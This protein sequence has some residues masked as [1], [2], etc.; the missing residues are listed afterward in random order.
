MLDALD[1]V[2][3]YQYL[4][5]SPVGSKR[6]LNIFGSSNSDPCDGIACAD[7]VLDGIAVP[8]L[9]ADAEWLLEHIHRAASRL[10]DPARGRG[11]LFQWTDADGDGEVSSGDRVRARWC[12]L[13]TGGPVPDF[14]AATVAARWTFSAPPAPSN[15]SRRQYYV[16]RN[17]DGSLPDLLNGERLLD[18]APPAWLV[19]LGDGNVAASPSPDGRK[20]VFPERAPNGHVHLFVTENALDEHGLP[21]CAEPEGDCCVTCGVLPQGVRTANGGIGTK[22][23]ARASWIPDP[24]GP[25]GPPRGTR[26]FDSSRADRK[27]RGDRRPQPSSFSGNS[28]T[29]QPSSWRTTSGTGLRNLPS[30]GPATHSPVSGR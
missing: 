18:E 26:C 19:L 7:L 6:F 14:E 3:L 17:A 11:G 24:A 2:F 25:S 8:R 1:A 16:Y 15:P 5:G 23:G 12:D 13:A 22:F 21:I 9:A 20:M 29:T 10:S 30:G 4:W 28:A 27:G